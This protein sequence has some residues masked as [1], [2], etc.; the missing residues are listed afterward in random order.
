MFEIELF[1]T[2]KLFRLNWIVWNRTDYLYENGFGIKFNGYIK[3][4]DD[5]HSQAGLQPWLMSFPSP[6]PHYNWSSGHWPCVKSLWWK[7]EINIRFSGQCSMAD[8]RL[9][10]PPLALAGRAA[11]WTHLNSIG[12]CCPVSYNQA[13]VPG[14][15]FEYLSS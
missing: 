15:R 12:P 13:S 9:K 6:N 5:Q 8:L 3:W 7:A 1:L 14:P 2:L 11:T 10:G 4:T